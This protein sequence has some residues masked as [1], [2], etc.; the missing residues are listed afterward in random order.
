[1]NSLEIKIAKFL[2]VG[3]IISGILMLIGWISIFK[4]SGNPFF[5]FEIYDQIQ[6]KEM[7]EFLIKREKWGMLVAYTGLALL[8]CLPLIRV[9]LTAFIFFK[10]KE[11]SLA[12]IA[13]IV[14]VGL[15]FSISLGFEL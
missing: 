10:Q 1:M 5:N 4:F 2:Q 11:Y 9:M 15:L 6:L 7:I 3:V 13:L 14:L 12:V 8:I